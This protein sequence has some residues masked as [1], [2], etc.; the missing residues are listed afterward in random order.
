MTKTIRLIC[1]FAGAVLCCASGVCARRPPVEARIAGL[2]G[3]GE[4]MSL[5]EEDARLQEREDSVVRAVEGMRRR[6]RENPA[7]LRSLSDEILELENRIFEIRTAKGRLIDKINTIE[8]NWVLANLDAAEPEGGSDRPAD[9]G[10]PESQKK[11]YLLAN[12]YFRDRLPAEDYAALQQAQ[13]LEPLAEACMRRYCANHAELLRLAEA[14]RAATA[15]EEAVPLF[16]RYGALETENG[17]LADSLSAMW[18]YICDNKNFAY[19]YLLDKLGEEEL[20]ALQERS[21]AEAA[22]SFAEL[23]GTTASDEIVDYMLRRQAIVDYETSVAALLGFAQAAD[24]LRG[25]AVRLSSVDFL[26]PRSE[27]EERCFLEYDSVAFSSSPKYDARNPIPECRIYA[28]GTIYRVL[29]GTFGAK[30]PPSVFRGAWPLSYRVNGQGKWCYYAGG[31]ATRREA[32]E[33][34][35][36]L[37]K[38]GFVR[39]EIVVWCDGVYRNVSVDGDPEQGLFRIEI[40]TSEALPEEV[41]EA[42][43]SSAGEAGVSRAGQKFVVGLFDDRTV[44]ERVESAVRRA[45]PDLEIKIVEA[46]E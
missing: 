26:L 20:L 29:L 7:D 5:L 32:E 36:R 33:T 16:D 31:F 18:N 38:R 11:R 25:V 23:A 4:Y 15:E 2:E 39:P 35:A 40:A 44:A 24:S 19:D 14:Y 41:R 22:G 30:R 6:L 27:L 9:P 10:I 8:Q 3:D 37:K 28:R 21:A 17:A 43:A 46:A 42:I 12:R 45:A 13:R 1:L 34:Q